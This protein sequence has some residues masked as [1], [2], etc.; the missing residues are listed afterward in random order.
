[1]PMDYEYVCKLP[2]CRPTYLQADAHIFEKACV[3]DSTVQ[4][5]YVYNYMHV[6]V[7]LLSPKPSHNEYT[8]LRVSIY[9]NSSAMTD[10]L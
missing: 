4:Q 6:Y 2:I 3:C 1:M 9:S 10:E 7:C 5:F 8:T